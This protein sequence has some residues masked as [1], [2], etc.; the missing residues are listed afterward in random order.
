MNK[1]Q[2]NK[3]TEKESQTEAG[4]SMVILALVLI[5]LLAFAGIAV[6]VGFAFVRSAQ[7]AAA[8][9]SA[10]LAGVVDLNPLSEVDTSEADIRAG[11][12]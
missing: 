11:N 12:F 6:D 1:L 9:D 7:F 3:Q 10:T 2:A 5:G 4:Q 8:V